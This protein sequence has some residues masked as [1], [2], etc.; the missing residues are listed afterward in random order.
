MVGSPP[1]VAKKYTKILEEEFKVLSEI[2]EYFITIT[3]EDFVYLPI[4]I[5]RII[6]QSIRKF[7]IE[8]S[9]KNN[10]SP[11]EIIKRLNQLFESFK[12]CN[13]DNKFVVLMNKESLKFLKYLLLSY[14]S[15]KRLI[16]KH[17]INKEAFDW[18]L[19]K[20]EEKFYKAIVHPGE[21]VGPIKI[22]WKKYPAY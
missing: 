13:D 4:N 8:A 17:N 16:I 11:I 10:I 3:N 7:N 22:G 2:K 15:S 20:I 14:L 9:T 6:Q 12:I 19:R 5:Y 1:L 18:I 21:M